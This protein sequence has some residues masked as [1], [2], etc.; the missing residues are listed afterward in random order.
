MKNVATNFQKIKEEEKVDLFT[1]Y[2]PRKG[3][4]RKMESVKMNL[5]KGYVDVYDFGEIKLHSYQTND[6]MNDES[7]ILENDKNVLLIEFPAFYDNLEEFEAYVKGLN[8]NIVGKVFSDHPNGGTILKDVKGYASEGT[9]KSMKEGTIHNLVTGF[10]SS[11]GG[12]FA[13]EY[14]EI[15]DVLKDSTVNIGGFELNITYYDENIEIEFP[16]INCIYTHMLGHDCHSIVAGEDQLKTGEAIITKGYNLPAKYVIHAVGP[17]IYDTVTQLEE[18]QL[19][20]CY[21]NSLQLAMDNGIRTIAFPCIS[22]GEFRFPKEQASK[23]AIATVDDFL[24]HNSD[25]FE[26]VVFN[27]FT[28]D[29]KRIY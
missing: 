5:K 20:D 10:E 1:R 26:K 3:N 12:A 28:E 21:I 11:F 6:L 13:K 4:E 18:Q 24:K 16:Q 17:M 14:H 23:I 9:I 8:K 27:V 22:T 19:A 29:D 15:T 2:G 25:K 7:Y